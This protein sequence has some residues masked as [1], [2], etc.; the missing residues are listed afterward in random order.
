[1]RNREI[2]GGCLGALDKD[3]LIAELDKLRHRIAEL[4]NE[5][6]RRPQRGAEKALRASESRL[7][8]AQRT[9]QVGDWQFDMVLINLLVALLLALLG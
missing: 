1:M 7:E 4:E 9:A 2:A 6:K 5:T 8:Q 3:Q